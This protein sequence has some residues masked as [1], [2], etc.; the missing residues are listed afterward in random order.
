MPITGRLD[1]R[2]KIPRD[3]RVTVEDATIR[4]HGGKGELSRRLWHPRVRLGVEGDEL[5]ITCELP[6]RVVI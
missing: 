3:V 2:V 5:R 6:R 4:V 1:E